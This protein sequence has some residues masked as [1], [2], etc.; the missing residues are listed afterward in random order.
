M[1]VDWDVFQRIPYP[2]RKSPVLGLS[3]C[4]FRSVQLPWVLKALWVG[5]GTLLRLRRVVEQIWRYSFC[6]Y[7]CTQSMLSS[8]AL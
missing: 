3:Q 7:C 5:L 6:R 2:Q 4:S 1:G 8:A